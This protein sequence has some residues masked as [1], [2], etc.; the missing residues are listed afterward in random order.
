MSNQLV[1]FFISNGW[2][3]CDITRKS[4][5]RKTGNTDNPYIYVGIHGFF[6][7]KADFKHRRKVLINKSPKR[8]PTPN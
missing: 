4:L 2:G 7:N 8:D 6:F 3:A 5:W 1:D